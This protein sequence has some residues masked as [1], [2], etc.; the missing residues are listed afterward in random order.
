MPRLSS[1]GQSINKKPGF[2]PI[3]F[4]PHPYPLVISTITGDT[5]IHAI[6]FR[7]RIR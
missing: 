3:S 1:R 5:A 7:S 6:H 4:R 2:S